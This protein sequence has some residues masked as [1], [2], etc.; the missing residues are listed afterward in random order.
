MRVVKFVSLVTATV[1]FGLAAC[2]TE[3][4]NEPVPVM[5]IPIAFSGSSSGHCGTFNNTLPDDVY[6][7]WLC[8]EV[9]HVNGGSGN[10]AA[11]AAATNEWNGAIPP[12]LGLP[13]FTSS[14]QTSQIT[15]TGSSASAVNGVWSGTR[16]GSVN[17]NLAAA[18]GSGSGNPTS[19]TLHEIG[20]IMGLGDTWDGGGYRTLGVSDHCVSSATAPGGT[21]DQTQLCQ[22]LVE[23]YLFIYGASSTT[24]SWDKHIV[25]SLGG[26]PLALTMQS[27]DS[28][29]VTISMFGVSRAHPTLCGGIGECPAPA[30]ITW[31]SSDTD[32]ATLVGSENSRQVI[33][34]VV[35]TATITIGINTS[36]YQ[37]GALMRDT[38]TVTVTSAPETLA[39]YAG[40]NQSATVGSTVAINPAV[41]LTVTANGSPVAGRTVTFRVTSGGGILTDSTPTTDAN[42]IAT[43]GSWELGS[44]GQNILEAEASGSNIQGNPAVFTATGIAPPSPCT[45]SPTSANLSPVPSSQKFTGSGPACSGTYM[46]IL[47][48]FGSFGF[49]ATCTQNTMTNS[50]AFPRFFV[51]SCGSSDDATLTLF[52]D[53]TMTNTVQMVDLV[54]FP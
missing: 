11:L 47:P 1:M 8:D 43:V 53:A 41:L 30:G 13:R 37:A 4:L 24:P 26:L 14:S 44:V 27:G 3:S 48:N 38:F 17:V 54:S 35:G 18:S 12:T 22:H 28:T 25:T 6:P 42:G 40:D 9:I 20:H 45:L 39:L 5:A 7:D 32:V 52:S 50:W 15:I 16:G 34:G 10:T 31:T 36:L 2:Q 19:I 23:L 49:N 51:Y 46:R 21:Y 29:P 33:A